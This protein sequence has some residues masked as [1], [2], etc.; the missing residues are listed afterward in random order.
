M[1]VHRGRV[2]RE[3]P[4]VGPVRTWE[5]TTCRSEVEGRKFRF[6]RATNFHHRVARYGGIGAR[7]H[8]HDV[9]LSGQE[10]FR[11]NSAAFIA[12]G[13]E[14]CL[15]KTVDVLARR[16]SPFSDGERAVAA[17]GVAISADRIRIG[18]LA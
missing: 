1:V 9:A 2:S 6:H 8:G 3:R 14:G 7:A 4:S 12:F 17:N 16:K 10:E 11:A 5:P 18:L 13:K 15:R